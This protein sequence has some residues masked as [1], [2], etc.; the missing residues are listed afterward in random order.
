MRLK[1]RQSVCLSLSWIVTFSIW[2]RLSAVG[3][4]AQLSILIRKEACSQDNMAGRFASAST[5]SYGVERTR[6]PITWAATSCK[7]FQTSLHYGV[8]LTKICIGPAPSKG[9]VAG[10]FF[11]TWNG[12]LLTCSLK[13]SCLL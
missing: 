6:W 2:L 1:Y 13:E 10:S 7:F 3:I 5:T 11:S 12:S 4:W 8:H 9:A